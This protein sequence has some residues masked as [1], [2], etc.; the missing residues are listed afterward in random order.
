MARFGRPGDEVRSERLRRRHKW[1]GYVFIALLAPLAYFGADFLAEM[2]D[3]LSPRGTFHFVLA[4]ALI[5]VLLLKFLIVKTYRQ[6]LRY[7]NALGM[8]LFTLTLIIF[9]ITAGYFLLQKLAV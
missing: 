8:T 2:G 6:L 1:A 5:A 9:L 4:M 7:A 3:G